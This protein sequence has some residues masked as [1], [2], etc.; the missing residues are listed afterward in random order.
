MSNRLLLTGAGLALLL[1]AT[2]CGD[3]S[4]AGGSGGGDLRGK[5][6]VS[7][8][9]TEQGKP[10]ALVEGT[11]VSL[12]FT[13][14]GRLIAN[15][16]CNMMQGPVSLDGGT[17]RV[18]DLST[19]AMGCPKPELHTQDDWLSKL[20]G[21]GPSWQ[22]KDANLVVTGP[23]AEIVL[24]PEAPAQLEGGEW[25]VDTLISAAA[26]SSV[27][28]A[29]PATLRFAGGKVEVFTGCNSGSASYR[30]DGRTITF[31]QLVHTDKACGPDETLVEKAVLAALTGQV[32]YKIDRS[33]L[34]LTNTQG[35]GVQLKK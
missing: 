32:T 21:A 19:T 20:L 12:R 30:V 3:R 8:S 7:T 35:D 23:D 4:A 27:P 16:G 28:G 29:V 13:D 31:E 14:D 10:R 11:S 1:A 24:A 18:T 17:L 9:V 25:K 26:A 22:L 33:S 15:A 2:G 5:V 6:F 34:S